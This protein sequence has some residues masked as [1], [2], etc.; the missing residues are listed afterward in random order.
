MNTNI[1]LIQKFYTAFQIKDYKSMQACYADNATFS[2]P[3]F[4]SLNANEVKA[5]WEMF[6]VRGEGI[7]IKFSNIVANE[8]RGTAKWVATYIFSLTRKKVVNHI[9]ASFIFENGKIVNH[10]DSFNF[11]A[12]AKQ[13][14]GLTGLLFGWT[15]LV[16]NKVQ[17][18]A[19]KSLDNFMNGK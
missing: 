2:D 12:W 5:M 7:E 15:S 9:T 13:A 3:V 16:K 18:T 10:T 11:Y 17:K 4:R 14:L 8:T 19:M 1:Q 6:C